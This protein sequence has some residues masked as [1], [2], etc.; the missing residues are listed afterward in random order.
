MKN[1]EFNLSEDICRE[2]EN[3]I[4]SANLTP[5]EKRELWLSIMD[6]ITRWIEMNT[7]HHE[8]G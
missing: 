1:E 4:Q 6:F 8:G 5:E 2:I 7:D 3:I